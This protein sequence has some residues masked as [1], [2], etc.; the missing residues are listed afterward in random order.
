M[1]TMTISEAEKILDIVSGAL[2]KGEDNYL[3]PISSLQGYNVF[4][5]VAAL[6][7]RIANLFLALANGEILEE[8]FEKAIQACDS[9]PLIIVTQFVGDDDLARLRDC[10]PNSPE[11]IKLKIKITPEIIDPS[12]GNFVDKK[13][14]S[15]E[16]ISSFA[17]YCRSVGATDSL[18]WQ[19]IYT[20]I[21]L[22]YTST[23]PIGNRPV[24]HVDRRG[25]EP[26]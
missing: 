9:I 6:K 21:G 4:H 13:L 17:N 24:G 23:S 25:Y 8:E 2:L 12:T 16:T 26:N 1:N 11:F 19:K 14:G 3:L 5:I 7:L 15:L 20:R 22:D 18:Y 10:E